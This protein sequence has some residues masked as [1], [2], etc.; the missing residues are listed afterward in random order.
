MHHYRISCSHRVR[1]TRTQSFLRPPQF[2]SAHRTVKDVYYNYVICFVYCNFQVPFFRDF[3]TIYNGLWRYC[4]L[5]FFI[6][7]LALVHVIPLLSE[8]KRLVR[9]PMIKWIAYIRS[10]MRK[11][12]C[13]VHFVP[14]LQ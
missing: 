13:F 14:N 10:S 3:T 9:V 2:P 6:A 1:N 8:S 5:L 4:F 7:M 12:L 11:P